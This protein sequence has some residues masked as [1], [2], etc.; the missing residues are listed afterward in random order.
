MVRGLRQLGFADDRILAYL[1]GQHG[2]S[3]D[4]V[5][6]ALDA[7]PRSGPVTR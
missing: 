1:G 5:A 4:A 6:P 2:M 3:P 7:P